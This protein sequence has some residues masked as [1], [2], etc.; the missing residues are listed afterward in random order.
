MRAV[1]FHNII[2]DPMDEFDRQLYRRHVNGFARTV[3]FLCERYE[4]VSLPA[5]L[6][7]MEQGDPAPEALCITFDDGFAGNY[8][9]AWPILAEAG[10]TATIFLPS[11]PGVPG[12]PHV[13][14][15]MR[16]L[17][18]EVLEIAFRLSEVSHLN[19]AALDLGEI[20]LTAPVQ[21]AREMNRIKTVLKSL[22]A[23]EAEEAQED[24]LKQLGVDGGRI[25]AYA[26][27]NPKYRKL[28]VEQIRTLQN[29]GWTIGGHTRNH[30]PL[31]SLDADGVRAEVEGNLHDL[32]ALFGVTNPPFAYPY[33]TPELV[34]ALAP[35]MVRAAGYSCAFTTDRRTFDGAS[36][37]FLLGRFSDGDLL[38]NVP[39]RRFAAG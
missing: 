35:E 7:R 17:H 39:A 23:V 24:I 27:A 11:E 4:I 37:R 31:S 15:E 18:F 25:E 1:V 29:S 20:E 6:S 10:A 26:A 38:Y 5:M 9:L 3:K 30:L 21:R 32:S 16:L 28:S 34:G 2:S 14:D 12:Q 8:E 13:V 19:A 33:G 22:P 36:E